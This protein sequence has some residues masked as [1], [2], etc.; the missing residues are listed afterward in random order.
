SQV[1]FYYRTWPSVA[2]AKQLIEDGRIGELVHVRGWMLQDYACDPTTRLGW[3]ADRSQAGAG[4]LGDLGSH[5]FDIFRYLAGDAA[6]VSAVARQTVARGSGSGEADDL[7]AALLEFESGVSGVLEAS[8]A[9][10]G[11]RSDLGFDV[12]GTDGAIRFGWEN[13]NELHVLTC[14][15]RSGGFE[16]VL[17]GPDQPG[18]GNIVAVAGQGLGYRDA[19]TI[20]L[21]TVARAIANGDDAAA[22]SFADGVRACEFVA[23]VLDSAKSGS[24]AVL[25][26]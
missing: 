25:G 18:V 19:F 5:I 8:W 15:S 22:P 23:G 6:R 3:R 16:R 21:G 17:V 2:L 14:D 10:R 1:C 20:G 11:H 13:A 12:I 24:W 26:Q 7:T 4:A 9:L